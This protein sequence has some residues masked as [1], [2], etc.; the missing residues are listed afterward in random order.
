VVYVRTIEDTTL[1]LIVSGKLWRNSLIMQDKETG[2]LWSHI[3][4]EALD[5]PHEGAYLETLPSVQTTWAEWFEEHPDTRVLKKEHEVLG[6]RYEKYF[7]DPDRAGMFR[8]E[9][10]KDRLPGKSIVYGISRGPFSVAILRDRLETEPLIH[11]RV[12]E[13]SLVVYLGDDGGVRAFVSATG[14]SAL[15]FHLHEGSGGISDAETGSA[16]DL[17]EGRS[18]GGPHTG[19]ILEEVKVLPI[20]WFA[21]SNF[22]PRT[23]IID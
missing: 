2:T 17:K 22:Y 6:S 8:V 19:S 7:R 23:E 18:T 21:W 9:W 11:T 15:S 5:G 14:T 4:G 12:G 20:F 16:W 1:T 13:D 3:T 10:L